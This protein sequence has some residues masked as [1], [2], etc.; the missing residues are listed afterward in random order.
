[1]N[2]VDL[3][4]AYSPHQTLILLLSLEYSSHTPFSSPSYTTLE[5]AQILPVHVTL[6]IFLKDKH[7]AVTSVFRTFK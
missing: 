6:L 5:S 3:H 4:L 7:D 2:Q 1:M